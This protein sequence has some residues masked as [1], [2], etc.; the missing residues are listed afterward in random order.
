MKSLSWT[1]R[2]FS[3]SDSAWSWAIA[4]VTFSTC[5]FLIRPLSELHGAFV[6]DLEAKGDDDLKVVVLDIEL[7]AVGDIY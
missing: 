7:S 2:Y 6:V 1:T 5:S 3:N 4:A